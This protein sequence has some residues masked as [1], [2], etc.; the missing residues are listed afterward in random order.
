MA[1]VAIFNTTL[2]VLTAVVAGR[3]AFRPAGMTAGDLF[4]RTPMALAA[5]LN[6]VL[7]AFLVVLRSPPARLG[8]TGDSLIGFLVGPPTRRHRPRSLRAL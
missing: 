7:V 3:S 5:I 6:T 4:T 1:L 8:T 2:T